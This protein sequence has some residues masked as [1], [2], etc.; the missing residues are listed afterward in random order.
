MII[1]HSLYVHEVVISY[2]LLAELKKVTLL[3]LRV[4]DI[5]QRKIVTITV[6]NCTR[7]VAY[8]E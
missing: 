1:L 8:T 2:N 5:A 7:Y 3:K 6:T 4:S